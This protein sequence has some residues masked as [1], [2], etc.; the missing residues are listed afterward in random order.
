M[1]HKQKKRGDPDCN[2]KSKDQIRHFYYRTWHKISPFIH[3][4]SSDEMK[5]QTTELLGVLCYAEI[6]KKV[7]ANFDEKLGRKLNELVHKGS[8]VL[9]LKGKKLVLKA[10]MCKAKKFQHAE[11]LCPLKA[12]MPKKMNI[13]VLP[14]NNK[15]WSFVQG[16]SQNPRILVLAQVTHS[17]ASIIN[18]L[19]LK[20]SQE[21]AEGAC[22]TKLRFHLPPNVR[23]NYDASLESQSKIIRAK[24]DVQQVPEMNTSEN[25]LGFAKCP[26]YLTP[27]QVDPPLETSF[28][29]HKQS[30][31]NEDDDDDNDDGIHMEVDDEDESEKRSKPTNPND[32]RCDDKESM[33]TCEIDE[34]SRKL[35][36]EGLDE[37]TG[38]QM[39]IA[40]LLVLLGFPEVI[41]L[42]YDWMEP[43]GPQL[44]GDV[45][46]E[47]NTRASEGT[48][49]TN[50]SAQP[51]TPPLKS[52][53]LNS[54]IRRLVEIACAEYYA[55]YEQV[56][57]ISSGHMFLLSQFDKIKTFSEGQRHEAKR[58]KVLIKRDHQW[59]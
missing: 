41:R 30:D 37:M 15:S 11:P 26:N 13:E 59:R 7:V 10:P 4:S 40:K 49:D 19:Q 58:S 51:K 39:T 27:T 6:R 17:V 56:Q 43:T 38:V 45:G 36:N 55:T 33:R 25:K 54:R 5:K 24:S 22:K 1:I 3:Q 23:L 50:T 20:W 47:G 31:S 16:L 2:F 42:E 46:E 34:L 32:K 9:K 29:N 18:F 48:G 52:P 12:L 28:L 14:K 57:E 21:K 53:F 35:L 44:P 8:T